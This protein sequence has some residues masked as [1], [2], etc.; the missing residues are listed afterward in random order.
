MDENTM[1]LMEEHLSRVYENGMMDAQIDMLHR[2]VD[3]EDID[4]ASHGYADGLAYI[5]TD[6]IRDIFGWEVSY[7]AREMRKT[8]EAE[9]AKAEQTDE[10]SD[11]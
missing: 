10:R 2:V 8:K 7:V 11:G 3:R 4:S 1:N 6:I 5:K 9:K